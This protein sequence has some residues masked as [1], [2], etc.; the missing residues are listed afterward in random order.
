MATPLGPHRICLTCW[1]GLREPRAFGAI[2]CPHGGCCWCGQN[3]L[4]VWG[5]QFSTGVQCEDVH[6]DEMEAS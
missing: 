1:N 2:S 3:S 4:R 6:L 5:T